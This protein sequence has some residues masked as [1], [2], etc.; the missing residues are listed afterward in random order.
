M[1]RSQPTYHESLAVRAS[2]DSFTS[3]SALVLAHEPP[4]AW[5]FDC[6]GKCR[7]F[8]EVKTFVTLKGLEVANAFGRIQLFRPA[9]P[10][11]SFRLFD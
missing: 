5:D 10:V 1:I 2:S 6:F 8:D 3:T 11:G 4:A 9:R 7:T